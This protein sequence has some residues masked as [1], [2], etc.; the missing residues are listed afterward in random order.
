[1]YIIFEILLIMSYLLNDY[2][3]FAMSI[4]IF[5][6]LIY[7]NKKVSYYANENNFKFRF[8]YISWK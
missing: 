4:I 1:M 5:S 3:G 6:L 7:K 2:L 8:L